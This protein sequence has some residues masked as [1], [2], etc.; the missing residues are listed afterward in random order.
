MSLVSVSSSDAE[1]IRKLP[2]AVLASIPYAAFSAWALGP[3]FLLFLGELGLDKAR[4]GVISFLWPFCG[5]LSPLVAPTVYR[6]GVKRAALL[7]W[8][9]RKLIIGLLAL[10][11]L[12]AQRL[13]TEGAFRWVAGIMLGFG[14]CRAIAETGEY[15]WHQEAV[16]N[17]VRGRLAAV[18]SVVSTVSAIGAVGL[19]AHVTGHGIGL[20]GFTT[21]F[22]LAAA[23]GLLFVWCQSHLLGGAPSERRTSTSAHLRGMAEALSDRNL[24]VFLVAQPLVTLASAFSVTFIPLYAKEQVGLTLGNAVS[25]SMATNAG[26]LLS[27]YLWGW[28]ADRHGSKPVMLGSLLLATLLPPSWFFMPRQGEWRL[29]LAM[30][31]SFIQGAMTVGWSI[32]YSRYLY[33]KAIPADKRSAYLSVYYPW[34][35]FVSGLGPL[36]AGVL[37]SAFSGA[38]GHIFGCSVDSYSPLFALSLACMVAAIVLV[39]RLRGDKA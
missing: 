36:L 24:R 14:V 34:T 18:T 39:R 9:I 10:T 31:A 33:V 5:L 4:I 37:L 23:M 7:F 11:P 22:V 29:A 25:L 20:Q 32:G 13:G 38:R 3:V 2:W 27:S 15:P 21:L 26:A 6:F 35:E 28:N 1:K 19:A 17:T 16:P 12:V 8:T 30:A